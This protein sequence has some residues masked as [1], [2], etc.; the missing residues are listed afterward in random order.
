MVS[1]IAGYSKEE[2]L[3]PI[4]RDA[5]EVIVRHSTRLSGDRTK[6]SMKLGAI[7]DLIEEANFFARKR[8]TKFIEAVDV[9]KALQE[10]EERMKLIVEKYDEMFRKEDLFI[11]VSGKVVGQVNGL[12]G[13]EFW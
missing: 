9:N 6:L 7:I 3:L 8:E 12:T 10:R 4:K 2:E 13:C 1:F 11:D 5:L